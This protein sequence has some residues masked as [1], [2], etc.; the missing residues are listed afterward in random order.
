[1][2][3]NTEEILENAPLEDDEVVSEEVVEFDE[4]EPET[5]EVDLNL[6]K[7]TE[8]TNDLQRT[9]ADFENYRKQTELQKSQSN[10]TARYMTVQKFLPLVDDF[11]RAISAYPDQLKPL[12]KSF[13]KTLKSLGLQVIDSA[14]GTDFN[15]DYHEAVT[16]DD[17]DGEREVISET[18]RPGYTYDGAVIRPAMVKVTH[19]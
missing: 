11:S 2:E 5:P 4:P 17:S 15:P 8:L 19:V 3:E 14:A 18:L 13:D 9:R 7:I 12:A 6:Q 16:V 1:M 10:A